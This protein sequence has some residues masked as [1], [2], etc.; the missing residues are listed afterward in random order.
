MIAP[1]ERKTRKF[2]E[3]ESYASEEA[4][5]LLPF[6]F[7]VLTPHK[8]VLVSEVGDYLIVPRGTVARIVTRQIDREVDEELYGDLLA[9][10]FIADTPELPLLDVMATRYRTKKAFL[11]HFTALHIFVVTLRC[12][13][14]CHYCQVSRVTADKEAFNMARH[15][16]ERGI[17]LMMQ[18]PNPHVTME[19]QGGEALLAFE[20][21]QYGV[22]RAERLA[23]HHGKRITFVVCTN[24]AVV[25][26]EMLQYCQQHDILVSTSL[27]G[28]EFLHNA[29]RHRPKRNSY[30][31][32]VRGLTRA[33]EWVGEDRVS[34]LMTTSTLSLEHPLAIV[35]EYIERGFKSIFLRPISPY[36]FALRSDKKNKY[37]TDTFLTFY[38][39]ALAHILDH[40]FRGH[41]FRE[42]YA[43]IILRKILTPFSVGYVDLQSPAGLVNSVVVFN[44]DGA[45][46]A[47]DEARMLAEM[48]DDTF[49]LG[50]LDT[51]SYQE[52][53]YGAKAREIAGVWSNESLAGCSECAFQPYCGADPVLHH[54]TQGDMY[55]HR[56][57]SVFCQKNMEIIRYLFELMDTDSRIEEIFHRWVTD[58]S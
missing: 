26:D 38:K 42:D 52:I 12:E 24:L 43:T 33:R 50:H 19:F 2:K 37:A 10:F 4:Y 13:H 28:P 23:Q 22:E 29:N 53:F 31:L 58:F 32:T 55:G 21:I 5:L 9:G 47:S 44:Y 54:A 16:L 51:H 41:H 49:R 27:D 36:G 17:D 6:R 7:H 11:D 3:A 15:H 25:T 35:N 8:E 30:E 48:Q 1:I 46:Y 56:P 57:T 18:S 20:L 14:T 40:N 45:V 39:T 34:A